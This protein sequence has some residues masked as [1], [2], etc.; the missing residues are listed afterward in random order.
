MSFEVNNYIPQRYPFEMIDRI[1]EVVPG[2]K[3]SAT[4]LLSIN[5]WFFQN[6]ADPKMPRPIV[7]E[8][9]AQTGV[10]SILSMD[11]YKGKN[12]FFGGIK[13]AEF[14]DHFRP[15][16]QLHLSVELSKL[17]RNIGVGHGIVKRDDQVICEAD[18]MFAIEG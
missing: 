8:A 4:K 15:G 3:A 2:E 11:E 17:K 18:L 14:F 5:E 6:Q 1:D 13:S 16:D 9:L 12:V 10:V 7:I